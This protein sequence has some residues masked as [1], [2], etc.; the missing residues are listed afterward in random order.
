MVDYENQGKQAVHNKTGKTAV[1]NFE[2]QRAS[3]S[4]HALKVKLQT[5]NFD[6]WLADE[7]TITYESRKFS[8]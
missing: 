4:R 7:V 8:L 5:G 1:V 3:D 2:Y 6:Y